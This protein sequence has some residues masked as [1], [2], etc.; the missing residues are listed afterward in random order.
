MAATDLKNNE[1]IKQKLQEPKQWKVVL[2]NDDYTT[3]DFV[4]SILQ[5]VFKHDEETAK[6]ITMQIHSTGSGIAGIYS[7]EIAEAKAVETTQL[8]RTANFPLQTKIEEE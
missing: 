2:V 3:V 6:A 1:K 7:F 8:A 4:I 5:S